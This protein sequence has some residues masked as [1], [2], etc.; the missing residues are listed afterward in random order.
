M[1]CQGD[2]SKVPLRGFF[3]SAFSQ[4]SPRRSFH[5]LFIPL[6]NP[7]TSLSEKLEMAVNSLV[8]S[9][10]LNF[11]FEC[12]LA[13]HHGPA[14]Q[15]L[16]LPLQALLTQQLRSH[17]IAEMSFALDFLAHDNLIHDARCS[18]TQAHFTHLDHEQNIE[19]ECQNVCTHHC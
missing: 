8:V 9:L 10:V 18:F 3:E 17:H 12:H 16:Q 11:C 19:H 6:L 14:M 4:T 15:L 13:T 7:G 2:G 5:D 1:C